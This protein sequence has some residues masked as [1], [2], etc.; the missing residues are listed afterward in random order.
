MA[1]FD[2][3][4]LVRSRPLLFELNAFSIVGRRAGG[5]AKLPLQKLLQVAMLMQFGIEGRGSSTGEKL[6]EELRQLEL[7]FCFYLFHSSHQRTPK[8]FCRKTSSCGVVVLPFNLLVAEPLLKE[9]LLNML[10]N[11]EDHE[12]IERYADQFQRKQAAKLLLQANR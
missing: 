6:R 2:A 12:T 4:N 1:F 9:I 10:Q 5:G 3:E 7:K 8:Q 11:R